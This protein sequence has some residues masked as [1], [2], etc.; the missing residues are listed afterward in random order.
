[1]DRDLL[2]YP[3]ATV[4][5]SHKM[6]KGYN[7][8]RLQYPQLKYY[9]EYTPV[10]SVCHYYFLGC[11]AEKLAPD[12]ILDFKITSTTAWFSEGF[13]A[14]GFA[15]SDNWKTRIK[16]VMESYVFPSFLD[17]IEDNVHKLL[18][19]STSKARGKMIKSIIEEEAFKYNLV[20]DGEPYPNHEILVGSNCTVVINTEN[21]PNNY[22]ELAS[23]AALFEVDRSYELENA[24]W[25]I[26]AVSQRLEFSQKFAT[27]DLGQLFAISTTALDKEIRDIEIARNTSYEQAARYEQTL[28]ELLMKRR[29]EEQGTGSKD[30]VQQI[31][32]FLED[33]KHQ[34]HEWDINYKFQR[35]HI[36]FIVPLRHY[37]TEAVTAFGNDGLIKLLGDP[38]D[39]QILT[40]TDVEIDFKKATV[41]RVGSSSNSTTANGRYY[42]NHP[43]IGRYNCWGS[44][45]KEITDMLLAG[46][47]ESALYQIIGVLSCV[48]FADVAGRN[49]L[50]YGSDFYNTLTFLRKGN[51][52]T[53][54]NLLGELLKEELQ[55]TN[56]T[57]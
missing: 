14:L 35:L 38:N 29:M 49:I 40:K 30:K 32:D 8:I 36:S 16:Q 31:V 51:E 26:D 44:S 11:I 47:I 20:P 25:F 28:Q 39:H 22:G 34:I 45:A 43:H 56:T 23:L 9:S 41:T 12:K 50:D 24:Q 3:S 13:D 6:M 27:E 46:N 18:V 17:N 15:S 48:D 42:L 10:P 37:A 53:G 55:C 57:K 1:M 21:Q 33:N 4:P 52:I 54:Q 5:V 7:A 2:Q 19:I